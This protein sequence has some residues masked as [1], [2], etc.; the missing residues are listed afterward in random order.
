[1]LA[2]Q[3]FIVLFFIEPTSIG[4][5]TFM[6]F[7]FGVTIV[8]AFP[9]AYIYLLEFMTATQ[10]KTIGPGVNASVGFNVIIFTFTM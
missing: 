3:S 8:G 7:L 9:I 2:L 5:T 1:M 10:A 6:L 4:L